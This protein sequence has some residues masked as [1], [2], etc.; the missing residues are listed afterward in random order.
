MNTNNVVL[1]YPTNLKKKRTNF[2]R[3][4]KKSRNKQIY[5]KRT[6]N[7]YLLKVLYEPINFPKNKLKR[8]KVSENDFE[9]P[10]YSEYDLIKKFNYNVFQLKQICRFYKQKVS[11]NKNQL[12]FRLYNYLRFSHFAIKLQKIYRGYLTRKLNRLRGPGYL[13][14]KEC[15]NSTDFMTLD[16]L[17]DIPDKQFY[18][19]QDTDGFIYG[20]DICSLYNLLIDRTCKNRNPYN[21]K[22]LPPKIHYDLKKIVRLSEVVN[23]KINLHID[24]KL[25]SDKEIE[26][27]TIDIFQLLDNLGHTT[28]HAWF[29]TLSRNRLLRYIRELYDIWTYRAQ[30]LP[31]TRLK[32]CPPNGKPFGD[33]SFAALDNRTLDYIQKYI[34]KV[35][36]KFIS[37]GEDEANRKVGAMYVLGALTIV[38]NNAAMAFPWLYQSFA[39]NITI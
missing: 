20:F 27:K 6:P 37:L 21:R 14:K 38:N 5:E 18:S 10:E 26:F 25:P 22:V 15:I 36:K 7:T 13:T 3:R 24:E 16:K 17:K 29:L 28:D 34:L 9:I 4:K 19:Y 33:E 32:V 12:L 11:G 30:M 23:R 35:M 2:F 31:E 1:T 8:K 39:H